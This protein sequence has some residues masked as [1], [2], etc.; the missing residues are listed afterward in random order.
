M[1]VVVAGHL[2]PTVHFS[3]HFRRLA[4]HRGYRGV[5]SHLKKKI[6][7]ESTESTDPHPTRLRVPLHPTYL[8]ANDMY[9]RGRENQT[10]GGMGFRGFRGFRGYSSRCRRTPLTHRGTRS[11]TKLHPT[12]NS[13]QPTEFHPISTREENGQSLSVQCDRA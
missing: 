2:V 12:T 3:G 5:Q 11:K 8:F 6:A 13:L 9:G 10:A 1:S 4:S 7:T